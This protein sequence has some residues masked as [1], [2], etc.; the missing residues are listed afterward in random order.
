MIN[1]VQRFTGTTTPASV[2]PIT[3]EAVDMEKTH[4][5]ELFY[6]RN[7]NQND[8]ILFVL[9]DPTTVE[10]RNT[11]ADDVAPYSIEVVEYL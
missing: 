4:I 2:V 9:V 3:I 5:T 1:K 8:S 10:M 11:T 6:F 7:G